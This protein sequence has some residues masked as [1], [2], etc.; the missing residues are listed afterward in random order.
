LRSNRALRSRRPLGA[1]HAHRTVQPIADELGALDLAPL[2][3]SVVVAIRSDG[4]RLTA[5]RTAR[6]RRY[7]ID[8]DYGA[9]SAHLVAEHA[10]ARARRLVVASRASDERDHHEYRQPQGLVVVVHAGDPMQARRGASAR[11]HTPGIFGASFVPRSGLI[12]QIRARE[13][14]VTIR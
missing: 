8:A 14:T 13:I 6:A 1:R 12:A 2:E 4:D 5:V 11:V 3:H 10:Q 9:S 7:A